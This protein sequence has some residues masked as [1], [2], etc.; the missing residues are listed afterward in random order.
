M[1][2][3]RRKLYTAQKYEFYWVLVVRTVTNDDSI[4]GLTRVILPLPLEHRNSYHLA[5][6]WY[7]MS[8]RD[9]SVADKTLITTLLD[10]CVH[11]EV[12]IA[13]SNRQGFYFSF[14]NLQN[15]RNVM[16]YTIICEYEKSTCQLQRCQELLFLTNQSYQQLKIFL[17][18][19]RCIQNSVLSFGIFRWIYYIKGFFKKW[20]TTLS[21]KQDIF[22]SFNDHLQLWIRL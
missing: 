9:S 3:K 12:L 21:L 15:V 7:S 18:S 14:F 19:L 20:T 16:A 11:F 8:Y 17:H 1:N 6:M 5:T 2:Y 13:E 22:R 10:F 4:S